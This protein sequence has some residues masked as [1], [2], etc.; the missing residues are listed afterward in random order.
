M[1]I[2][3]FFFKQKT[4]YE[5]RISDWS[6][7]VGSSDLSCSLRNTD[8]SRCCRQAAFGRADVGPTCD[9]VGGVA[10]GDLFRREGNIE[11]LFPRFVRCPR[12]EERRVGKECGST[13]RYR[14]SQ[15]PS[16]KN[17]STNNKTNKRI[18]KSTS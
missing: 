8:P 11:D 2:V 3:F 5:M 1:C 13:G 9:K 12:S 17:T 16:Q 15:H 6:S 10:H 7:D 18:I 14:R 4:A